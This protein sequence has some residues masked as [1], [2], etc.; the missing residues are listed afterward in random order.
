MQNDAFSILSQYTMSSIDIAKMT[1]NY[2]N[3]IQQNPMSEQR[4]KKLTKLLTAKTL[5]EIPPEQKLKNPNQSALNDLIIANDVQEAI[6]TVKASS[7]VG[8]NSIPYKQ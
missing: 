2:H 5:T 1:R 7:V 3:R 6:Y 4:P 8:I